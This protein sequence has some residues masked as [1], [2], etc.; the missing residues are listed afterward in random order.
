MDKGIVG[1][2]YIRVNIYPKMADKYEILNAMKTFV[3]EKL[4][5]NRNELFYFD[6]R[7]T[8][9]HMNSQILTF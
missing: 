6:L 8:A 2:L 5:N 9:E 1:I 7:R 3:S 4:G